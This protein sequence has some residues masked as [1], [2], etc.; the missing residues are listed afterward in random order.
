MGDFGEKKEKNKIFKKK[1]VSNFD[2]YYISPLQ[3]CSTSNP[4]KYECLFPHT[5][6]NTAQYSFK[7]YHILFE[8]WNFIV[9]IRISL[10]S[11]IEYFCIY[12]CQLYLFFHELPVYT[13]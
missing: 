9:L 6:P 4:M 11:E 5:L 1:G 8:K 12:L 10:M 7:F 2:S 3:W 13:P